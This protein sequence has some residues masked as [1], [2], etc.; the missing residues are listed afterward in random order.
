M[1]ID[2]NNYLTDSKD[3]V[4]RFAGEIGRFASTVGETLMDPETGVHRARS[5]R[6]WYK[7]GSPLGV[8]PFDRVAGTTAEVIGSTV[9]SDKW[10]QQYVWP[11]TN[12]YRMA[13]MA[14]EKAANVTGLSKQGSLAVAAGVPILYHTL[15]ETSGP[16]HQGLRPK[17]WQ[18]S[19]PVSKDEDP[20]GKTS[21][22]LLEEVGNR[23]VLGQKSQPLPYQQF[24]EER[25]DVMPTTYKEY[26]RYLQKRPPAGQRLEINPQDQSFT[27]LGGAIRGTAR[28]LHDPEIRIKGTPISFN[29]TL[30]TAAGI[31]TVMAGKRFLDPEFMVDTGKE[32]FPKSPAASDYQ[33]KTDNVGAGQQV[34]T[35]TPPFT[36]DIGGTKGMG[37]L[38]PKFKTAEGQ[39]LYGENLQRQIPRKA[40]VPHKTAN[41]EWGDTWRKVPPIPARYGETRLA[42][43]QFNKQ[44]EIKNLTRS[45][46]AQ[47]EIPGLGSMP[48][49]T[50]QKLE[51]AT[52]E[53]G[54]IKDAVGAAKQSREEFVKTLPQAA[55]QFQ[56]L[57]KWKEPALIAGGLAA[58]VGTAAVARE[59]FRKAAEK[60]IEKEDPVEYLQYKHGNFAS[61]KQALGQ[62]TARNWQELSQSLN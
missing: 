16:L 45:A 6:N 7:G 60:R 56:K 30:G 2:V 53:L 32:Y 3:F 59:L 4:K 12:P 46:K 23:F 48:G 18:A 26:R 47:P 51:T 20:T 61:A 11:Y 52:K 1:K 24:R 44:Q 38:A 42:T 39:P 35:R 28:G 13:S 14:A 5:G 58:A 21:R 9:A 29:A 43:E 40:R 54:D 49:T 27:A 15:T 62:P 31:G 17:G 33:V 50:K 57:G 37:P 8:T 22:N 10:R 41:E 25:P 34:Y 55:Q 36:P 19:A